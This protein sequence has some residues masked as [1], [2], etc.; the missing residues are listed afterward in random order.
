MAP[1]DD[2]DKQLKCRILGTSFPWNPPGTMNVSIDGEDVGS[3][4]YGADGSEPMNFSCTRGNHTFRFS[5]D[6][7]RISCSGALRIGKQLRFIPGMRVNPYNGAAVC[8]L[9]PQ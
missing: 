5:V 8:S 1:I 3:F 2:D 4:D 7:T 6:G 9:T